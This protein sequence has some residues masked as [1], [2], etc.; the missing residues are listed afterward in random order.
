MAWEPAGAEPA[1]PTAGGVL[2]LVRPTVN[3]GGVAR[4]P[5]QRYLLVL[6][7]LWASG[8]LAS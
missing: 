1:L 8:R 3:K 5:G 7:S 4:G 2:D 6:C